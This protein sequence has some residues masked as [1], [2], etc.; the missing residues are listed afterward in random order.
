MLATVVFVFF[1][2]PNIAKRY[3]TTLIISALI[4]VIAGF[5][6]FNLRVNFTASYELANGEYVATGRLL[7]SSYRYI[8]WLLTVPLLVTQM[9]LILDVPLRRR[10][11][12]VARSAV[13]AALMIGPGYPGEISSDTLTRSLWGFAS[14]IPFTYLLSIMWD[15]LSDGA[16]KQLPHIRDLYRGARLLLLAS[17]GFYPMVYLLPII[18]LQGSLIGRDW[19]FVGVQLGYTLA[20]ITAKIGFGL[21]LYLIAQ[22]KTDVIE[23]DGT[24]GAF[25]MLDEY[26]WSTENWDAR[27][28]AEQP[29]PAQPADREL[30]W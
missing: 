29:L 13:A 12:L 8:D 11:S 10:R 17:W 19:L 2:Q 14:T 9:V 6:Y 7:G 1:V 22:A 15:E 27:S 28:R 30:R 5:H 3:R 25:A 18:G 16:T 21:M 23:G 26:A 24:P 20:D 4:A